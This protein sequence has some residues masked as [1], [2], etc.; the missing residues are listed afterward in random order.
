MISMSSFAASASW[1]I[2]LASCVGDLVGVLVRT[3]LGVEGE[4]VA[5][6][7]ARHEGAALAVD[8][9]VHPGARMR[10]H[11]V[12]FRAAEIDGEHPPAHEV[13]HHAALADV[14]EAERLARRA[15]RRR[16]RRTRRRAR[17]VCPPPSCFGIDLDAVSGV[18]QSQSCA[19]RAGSTPRDRRRPPRAAR[20]RRTSAKRDAAVRP[21]SRSRS[22]SCTISRAARADGRLKRASSCLV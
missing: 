18:A 17:S 15:R 19:S 14:A 10:Q 4:L 21:R 13:A 5:A 6:V 20:P 3:Q 7:H 12:E 8:R 16:R 22:A 2:A 9:P 1:N 11:V